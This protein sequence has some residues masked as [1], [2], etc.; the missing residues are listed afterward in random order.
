MSLGE[1]LIEKELIK[2]NIKYEYQYPLEKTFGIRTLFRRNLKASIYSISYY[3]DF[4]LPELKKAIEFQGKQHWVEWNKCSKKP[5]SPLKKGDLRVNPA[6]EQIMNDE[7]KKQLCEKNNI[8]L[9]RIPY[10][11][12]NK[13]PRYIEKL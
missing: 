8:K 4:Y 11:H 1:K 6:K 5:W 13:I 12:I 3:L 2:H 9:I 10:W 7:I